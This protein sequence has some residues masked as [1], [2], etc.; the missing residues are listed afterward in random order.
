MS[1]ADDFKGKLFA[2]PMDKASIY[3]HRH[4]F[5]RTGHTFPVLINGIQVGQNGPGTYLLV[6]VPRGRYAIASH[7]QEN[8]TQVTVDAEV[9]K[10]YFVWQEAKMGIMTGSRTEL[11]IV[12]EQIGRAAVLDSKR[13][14][15]MLPTENIP[16]LA[17][18]K[19]Y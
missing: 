3:I 5:Y 6:E 14:K 13:S 9:G 1:P 19:Q 11:H 8:S 17:S 10:N 12:D 7:T 18:P 16:L 15:L 2:P 4:E